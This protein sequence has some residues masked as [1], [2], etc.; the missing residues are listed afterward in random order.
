VAFKQALQLMKFAAAANTFLPLSKTTGTGALVLLPAVLPAIPAA[1]GTPGGSSSSSNRDVP[2]AA[3]DY[4]FAQSASAAP[5]GPQGYDFYFRVQR[6]TQ[7]LPGGG[8]TSTST[9]PAQHST[10]DRGFTLSSP[11]CAAPGL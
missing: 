3:V 4:R 11:S 10:A 6:L 2:Q 5:T 7:D 1:Q 9:A 8:C